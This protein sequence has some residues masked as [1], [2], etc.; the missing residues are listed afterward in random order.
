ML[1]FPVDNPFVGA[2]H[3]NVLSGGD[4]N[5]RARIIQSL[6]QAAVGRDSKVTI[7]RSSSRGQRSDEPESDPGAGRRQ[8]RKADG[9]FVAGIIS[10]EQTASDMFNTSSRKENLRRRCLRRGYKQ[11]DLLYAAENGPMIT[12]TIEQGF[13]IVK[14]TRNITN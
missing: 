3:F 9:R 14:L 2:D 5:S 13:Y 1:D 10:S 6:A 12:N 11:Q 4:G 7:N 8:K